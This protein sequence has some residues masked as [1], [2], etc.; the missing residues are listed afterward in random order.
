VLSD[1]VVL[2]ASYEGGAL[3]LFGWCIVAASRMV[4]SDTAAGGSG[5]QQ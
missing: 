3:D 2:I 1:S 5:G 4:C